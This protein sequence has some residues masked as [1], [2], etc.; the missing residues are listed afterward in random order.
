MALKY[1]VSYEPNLTIVRLNGPID[2]HVSD[3]LEDLRPQVKTPKLIFD[4]EHLSFINS[5]GAANWMALMREYSTIEL[6]FVKCPTVF[7]NLCLILPDLTGGGRIDS[8]FVHYF[9]PGCEEE[10][11]NQLV[12]RAEIVKSGF[13]P[14]SCPKCQTAMA[15]DPEDEDFGELLRTSA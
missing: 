12:H 3:A 5:I 6:C 2:E 11:D 9:C 7:T 4:C 1:K 10:L 15:V 14:R 8:L 13:P